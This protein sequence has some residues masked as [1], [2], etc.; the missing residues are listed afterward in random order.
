MSVKLSARHAQVLVL[1][2]G[3]L[4]SAVARADFDL[5][6]SALADDDG[7]VNFDSAVTYVP[8]DHWTLGA[9]LGHS[10]SST[11][12][13]DFSG[14]SYGLSA[15]L[16]NSQFGARL[17]WRSWQDSNDFESRVGSGKLY[18]RRD[19][20][21]IGLL[22]EQRDFDV[23]YSFTLANRTVS[24]TASFSGDGVGLSVSWYGEV[25][26]AYAQYQ[27]N[28]YDDAL[29]N[30]LTTIVSVNPQTRPRLAALSASILSRASGVTDNEFSVGLDRSF[31]RSGLRV[32]AYQ[33]KDQI[34]G[35][36]TT[37]V[38]LGYRY[39]IT[40]LVSIEATVGSA[41]SDGFDNQA[42]GGLAISIRH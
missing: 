36:D 38:S 20:L 12:F 25:W 13:S 37:G 26:G 4:V 35:G 2:C 14:T 39:S 32:D 29:S 24:R 5:T 22:L 6:L 40:S 16:H 42:Y 41:D 19:A 30:S 11:Q 10:T 8:N 1:T 7:G 9:S 31:N 17:A 18:W 28:S 23:Q 21:E 3:L 27:D 15:D 34:S 33:F